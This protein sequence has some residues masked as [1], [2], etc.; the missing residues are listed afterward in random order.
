MRQPT[1]RRGLAA[2]AAAGAAFAATGFTVS[3]PS[4]PDGGSMPARFTCDG[5]GVNPALEF[6]D[7]PPGT[8]GFAILGWDESAAGLRATWVAYDLPASATGVPEAVP[9]GATAPGGFKQGRNSAGRVGYTGPCPAKGSAAHRLY[10]DL[11]ALDAPTLG[12][13]GGAGLDAV[14]AAIKKHRLAEAK[15]ASRYR[16]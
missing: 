7:P 9:E 8:R 12:L 6:R 4:L 15:L 14:H 16:R 1:L 2:L 13:P 10:F 11:Y 5:A 3:S